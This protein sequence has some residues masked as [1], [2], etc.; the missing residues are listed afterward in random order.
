MF[1]PQFLKILSG[2]PQSGSGEGALRPGAR[3]ARVT[4]AAVLWSIRGYPTCVDAR[5][6]A[7]CR[8][9]SGALACEFDQRSGCARPGG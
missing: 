7:P 5:C 1:L 4:S 3:T 2:A 8:L 9:V 6:P